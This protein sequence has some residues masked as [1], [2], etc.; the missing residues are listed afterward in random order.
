MI[1]ITISD[2]EQKM[3]MSALVTVLL[4]IMVIVFS[5]EAFYAALEGL[6]V[7]WEIVFPSLLP[8]FIIA[9]ILM[10][11][12]V[13]HFLGAL[14]EPLMRPLFR[15]PGVGAFAFSMGLASGYPIGAKIT[16]NLRRKKLCSK[17]EAERLVS[18]TNTADPLFMIGA[19]A[20]GMFHR[21]DL[22][23]II[24][25]AHYLSSIMIGLIMRF[26]KGTEAD[27]VNTIDNNPSQKEPNILYRALNELLTARKNDGRNFGEL[28]GDSVRESVN[29]LLMVGGMI[30]LFSV[31]TKIIVVTGIIS[32]LSKSFLFFFAPLGI[33]ENLIV[34]LFSGFFEITNGA[35]LTSQAAAPLLYKVILVNVIIAWSGL[36][37]HAQV[38]TMVNNTDISLKPYFVARILQSV[39]AGIFTFLLFIPFNGQTAPTVLLAENGNVLY[40]ESFMLI[41]MSFL[42]ILTISLTFSFLVTAFKN[43]F[44]HA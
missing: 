12:G 15:V 20:V 39:F 21:A 1:D 2:R 8:F 16:A 42:L 25:G 9:E 19:V 31:V 41:L 29:T 11:L 7:W 33:T 10:G 14:L 27:K 43:I 24:T 6:R 40:Q 22:A 26:Y 13:V 5:E 36:S 38:A 34:P 30:I 32:L 37:V 3:V 17:T 18:F 23:I 28:L 4:T 35:N 44:D